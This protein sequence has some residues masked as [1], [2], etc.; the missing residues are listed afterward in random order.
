MLKSIYQQKAGCIFMIAMFTGILGIAANCVIYQQKSGKNLLL[1]KLISDVL[2]LLHYL[3]LSAYSGCAIALIGVFRELI[4][5]REIQKGRK[6]IFYP[7]FF[8]T[9]TLSSSILTWKGIV[10]VF[11]AIAS[12]ISIVSFWKASPTLSRGLA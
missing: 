1:W 4:F 8:I 9:V 2:W 5:Y 6:N 12:V 7:V 10:S 3:F 11:P